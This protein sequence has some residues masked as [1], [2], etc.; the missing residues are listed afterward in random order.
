MTHA[1]R[2]EHDVHSRLLEC[3][4]CSAI[5]IAGQPCPH[6]GFLPQRPPKPVAIGDGDLGLVTDGRAQ[7]IQHDRAT[8]LQWLAMF[9]Y[10]EQHEGKRPKYALANYR[11]KFGEWPSWGVVVEPIM[12]TAEC[13]AWVRSRQIAYAKARSAA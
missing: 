4:Q 1:A 13:R 10:I 7:R 9:Q 12:P 8:K 2:C 11:Q 5:R 3:S 6:C